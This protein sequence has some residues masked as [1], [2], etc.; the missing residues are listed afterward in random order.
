MS[1]RIV[2]VTVG[3]AGCAF[4]LAPATS[5][6]PITDAPVTD[7]ADAAMCTADP[8]GPCPAGYVLVPQNCAFAAGAFCIAKYEAK[9][10]SNIAQSVALG[11]P[12]GGLTPVQAKAACAANGSRYHLV[13]NAE[14]M[15]TARLIEATPTNWSTVLPSFLSKGRTDHCSNCPGTGCP[16]AADLDTNPCLG[17]G[18]SNCTDR[19]SSD[20]A[21]NRTHQL[22]EGVIWDFAG[23]AFEMID[24]PATTNTVEG[25]HPGISINA[26]TGA[27]F[28]PALTDGSYKSATATHTDEVQNIG[29]LY[30]TNASTI[31][32]RGGDYCGFAGIYSVSLLA[33]RELGYNVGF[34][35]AYK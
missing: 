32:T 2:V 26:T 9:Y 34:R 11:L 4:S 33:D 25:A 10:V 7:A 23:N 19:N 21:S 28:S 24:H 5:D 18:T 12:W 17:T 35:C 30:V 29:L 3:L 20:F 27:N 31:M 13:T 14:W 15:A 6:A 16:S 1:S 22:P 8:G